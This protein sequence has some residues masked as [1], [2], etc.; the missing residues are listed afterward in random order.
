MVCR[1]FEAVTAVNAAPATSVQLEL[2]DDSWI[3]PA[4]DGPVP[5]TD[6]TAWTAKHRPSASCM[7]MLDPL[8]VSVTVAGYTLAPIRAWFLTSFR[9]V[10]MGSPGCWVVGWLGGWVTGWS[11]GWARV[12]L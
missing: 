9:A 7:S 6:P 12:R 4:N 11:G 2:S 8:F 1:L 3:L 5:L 10:D